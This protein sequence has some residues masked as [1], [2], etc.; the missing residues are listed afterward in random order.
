MRE[1]KVAPH[2]AIDCHLTKTG[3]QRKIAIDG[4]IL[5]YVGYDISQRS[6][7]RIEEVF[8]WAKTTGA[9]ARVKV[10]DLAKVQ[11]VFTFAV[12]A[13]NL[14]RIPKLLSAAT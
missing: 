14:L 2:I 1:R 7:K 13:Y 6:R 4:R 8:G 12:L 5:R 10:R 9:I 3:K 11:A